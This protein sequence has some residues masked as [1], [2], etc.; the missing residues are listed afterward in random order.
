MNFEIDIKDL[1]GE[2]KPVGETNEDNKRIENIDKYDL[3]INYLIE[4]LY[5]AATYK[6]DEM[7]SRSKVGG[8]AF[9]VLCELKTQIE[10][11]L[12]LLIT[13]DE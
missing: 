6:D 8:K 13:E 11:D 1:I 2:I 4:E 5:Q 9:K 3:L 12:N 10:D 7:H